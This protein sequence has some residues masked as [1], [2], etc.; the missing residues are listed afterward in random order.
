MDN[1]SSMCEYYSATTTNTLIIF[2]KATVIG[3][4][5]RP[6][7]LGT[8]D[9]CVKNINIRTFVV[10]IILRRVIVWII[11]VLCTVHV[12]TMVTIATTFFI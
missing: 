8:V 1:V 11:N 2:Y 5:I 7:L 6:Q 12:I 3:L 10:K 4:S 9:Q